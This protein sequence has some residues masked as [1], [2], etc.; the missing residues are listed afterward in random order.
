MDRSRLIQRTECEW[1]VEPFGEMRV[2]AIL[3]ADEKLIDDMDDKV[4]EQI[5]HVAALPGAVQA[6]YTMP[7]AHWGYGFPIGGVAAFD[8][9][10]NGIISAGGVGFDISC[11]V[12]T[13][14][15]GLKRKD[16]E[17]YKTKLADALF[18]AIPAGVGSEGHIK[19]S[20]HELDKMLAGGAHW[21][22]KKGWGLEEDLAHTEDNGIAKNAKPENVSAKAK[23]RQR[24]EMGTLGSGNHYL[25]VQ[26]VSQI[27]D[28]KIARAF[29]LE[30]D[31]I[32]ISIHCGS[33]GL[34]HQI[35][36]EFL[37]DMTIEA[38]KHHIHLPDREL[39]CA[40]INSELGQ[41]YLGAMRAGIN[42][43]LANRQILTHLVRETFAR[44]IPEAQ[45]RMLYD[46]SHNTCK[47]ETYTI[48]GRK[49]KLFVHRKGATRAFGPHHPEIPDLFRD[50]GQPVLIGGSMGTFSYILVGTKESEQLS[51]S[52]SCHGAGRSLSRHQASKRWQGRQLIEELAQQGIIIRSISYRGIAEEAPGAYKDVNTVVDVAEKSGISKKVVQLRPFICVKG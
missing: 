41:Q 30:I 40:P 33:R 44:L 25:E 46:V 28:E 22:V 11:G 8:P 17:P 9:N 27:F 42:C 32:V 14:Y 48:E 21:A 20:E 36:T 49:R 12:R 24:G 18:S 34:G 47:E 29:N 6:V 26:Q 43:A 7:D 13:L 39:A 45:I 1:M 2:P 35:G 52:S 19:L 3:F 31:D 5:T 38:P 51:F 15:T 10:E 23:N 37:R 50:T 4:F 16:I